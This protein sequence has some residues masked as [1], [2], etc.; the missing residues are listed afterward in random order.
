MCFDVSMVLF[1]VP[2]CQLTE[3]DYAL[4][5]LHKANPTSSVSSGAGLVSTSSDSDCKFTSA[6]VPSARN[7]VSILHHYF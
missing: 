3:R 4:H 6:A 1:S 5:I 2:E 7:M